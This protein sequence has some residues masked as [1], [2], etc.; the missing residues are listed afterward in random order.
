MLLDDM[1]TYLVPGIDCRIMRLYMLEDLQM[2][3]ILSVKDI[4]V[5]CQIDTQHER[6]PNL[7]TLNF[8]TPNMSV[9]HSTCEV[10]C[11]LSF[12]KFLQYR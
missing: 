11:H 7:P 3:L 12:A 5:E 10:E 9:R 6:V 8:K 2:T 4:H 1:T